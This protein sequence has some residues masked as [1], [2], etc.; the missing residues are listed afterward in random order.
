MAQYRDCT[1]LGCPTLS[2]RSTFA[3]PGYGMGIPGPGNRSGKRY[4]CC[5]LGT[6]ITHLM[7]ST[8]TVLAI[9]VNVLFRTLSADFSYSYIVE[10]G[11]YRDIHSSATRLRAAGTAPAG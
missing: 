10:E 6:C 7:A 2:H 9:S 5:Q 11:H 4:R 8:A 3:P 1:E